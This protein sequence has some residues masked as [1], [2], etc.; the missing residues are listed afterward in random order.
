[1]DAWL[2]SMETWNGRMADVSR[3]ELSEFQVPFEE[4]ISYYAQLEH[5]VSRIAKDRPWGP[6]HAFPFLPLAAAMC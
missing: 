3:K 4:L 6:L 2:M 5:L 1:M